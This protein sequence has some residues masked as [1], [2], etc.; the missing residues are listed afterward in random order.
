MSE[1]IV[2]GLIK[3]GKEIVIDNPTSKEAGVFG[4]GLVVVA[5]LAY[6]TYRLLSGGIVQQIKVG[7][8]DI[9]TSGQQGD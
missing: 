4:A 6:G 2:H 5:G 9:K 7:P 1:N 3:V 8:V